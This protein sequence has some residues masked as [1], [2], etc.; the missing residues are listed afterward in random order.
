MSMKFI[1]YFHE[2]G[3]LKR[4]KLCEKFQKQKLERDVVA[5]LEAGKILRSTE[6]KFEIAGNELNLLLKNN[7]RHV[8]RHSCE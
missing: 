6:I 8:K 3:M 2:K 1:L 5:Y 4:A 7:I